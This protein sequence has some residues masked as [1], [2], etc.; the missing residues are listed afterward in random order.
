MLNKKRFSLIP[1]NDFMLDYHCS[2]NS[3]DVT[4]FKE[5]YVF[6]EIE[7]DFYLA[8]SLGTNP[9][10]IKQLREEFGHLSLPIKSIKHAEIVFP[11]IN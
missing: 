9:T 11:F 6:A 8:V 3:C 4:R 7:Q 1:A 5:I 2:V 10:V